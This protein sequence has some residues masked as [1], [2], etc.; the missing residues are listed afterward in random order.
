ML[1]TR[2]ITRGISDSFAD[3]VVK[4]PSAEPID[5][6][7]ARAQHAAYVRALAGA[8]VEVLEL[9][10]AHPFPDACFVEDCALVASG[11]ALITR[12]GAPS[13]QGEEIAVAGALER[14]VRIE[15]T[16]APATL[17]GGD[18]LRMGKTWFVGRTPRTNARGAA[19]VAEAFGPL[20]YRVVEVPVHDVLHLKCVCSP[21][22]D[23]RVLVAKGALDPEVFAGFH[24]LEIPA[25]ESYAANVLSVN[26]H[27]VMA[28]GF[29]E[30]RRI[31]ERAGFTVIALDVSELRKADGS[32]T[33]C[34]IPF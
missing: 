12:P 29:P 13:R 31:V 7:R 27:V 15:T 34:S 25:H 30:T 23:Q 26:G 33:C 4:A 2:A 5:V 9:P 17:D 8:G 14:F 10:P 22:D 28:D 16:A 18:C 20:G 6:V 19:R 24:V 3:A 1:A 11:V 32:L 21:L